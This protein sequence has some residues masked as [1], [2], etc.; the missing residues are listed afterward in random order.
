MTLN[1]HLTVP[2]SPLTDFSW[3]SESVG[4]RPSAINHE[5]YLSITR[6]VRSQWYEV[7]ISP[8][9][10]EFVILA[11]TNK[12]GDDV[13]ATVQYNSEGSVTSIGGSLTDSG[14]SWSCYAD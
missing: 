10:R 13:V 4:T 8:V 2:I 1:S 7:N 14:I 6:W 12:Y 9:I 5:T 3:F 11:E